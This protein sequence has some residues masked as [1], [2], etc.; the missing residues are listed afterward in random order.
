MT[1]FDSLLSKLYRHDDLNL[2]E[3]KDNVS[4]RIDK[5]ARQYLSPDAFRR[6]LDSTK[7][8]AYEISY[9]PSTILMYYDV[10]KKRLRTFVSG[11]LG[12]YDMLRN[13][14]VLNRYIPKE[15][16]EAVLAHERVHQATRSWA[17][18]YF[19]RFGE[20]ARPIVEGFT[21]LITRG[22]GYFSRA[23]DEYVKAAEKTIQRMGYNLREGLYRILNFKIDPYVVAGT[24][25]QQIGCQS[26]YR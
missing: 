7:S 25:Y 22:L 24:F 21:E 1:I 18:E 17:M 11:V 14:I 3:I 5:F 19:K 12:Y 4:S 9:L 23:Y 2:E 6:Y 13:R 26:C 20:S 8:L 10:M 16:A 15:E